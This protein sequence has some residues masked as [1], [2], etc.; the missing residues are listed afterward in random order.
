MLRQVGTAA[1]CSF[2][3]CIERLNRAA[4]VCVEL[5]EKLVCYPIN[6]SC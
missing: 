6:C 5:A 4:T 1:K 3:D 2:G